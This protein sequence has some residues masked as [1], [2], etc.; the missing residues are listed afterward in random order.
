MRAEFA[1][2][3]MGKF[4]GRE[5]HY[6]SDLDLIF[7]YN[8]N[9]DTEGR[10]KISNK[11]FYAYLAQKLISYLTVHTLRGYAFKV[12]TQLRP[13][14]NQGPLIS[15]LDAFADYQRNFA[16]IWEKQA[17]LKA[18]FVCGD[19]VFGKSLKETLQ[20]FIFSTEFPN[21]LNEEIHNM[22]MRMEKELAK[23]SPRRLHYKQGPG[24]IVDIEFIVQYL[25]LKMG[26]IFD[27]I[28]NE[29]T[30]EAIEKMGEREVLRP[31]EYESLK[32]AYLF[33]RLLETRL[34]LFF[35]LKQ[36]YLDPQTLMLENIAEVMDF[37]TG[38]E[39]L[40]V[41]LNHRKTVRQI[42]LRI[43]QVETL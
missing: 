5:M 30:L 31:P 22:R 40:D 7:L 9:G 28:V 10:K 19:E 37:E 12:D 43:L 15:S 26:K 25:Q 17:L 41:F 6:A 35:D 23:E 24:G 13:S 21:N 20:H 42:Y 32:Q 2:I 3:A 4:G 8:R 38:Q 29:N 27:S 39:M 16:K 11:E 34:E 36:G 14:G 33:Y 18:R 1:I